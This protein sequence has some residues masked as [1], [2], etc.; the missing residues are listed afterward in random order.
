MVKDN[1][2]GIKVEDLQHIFAFGFT[3][4]ENGHGFG[5]HSS[6]LSAKE[7]AGKLIAESQGEGCG[8]QFI[9]TLP[10]T[11]SKQQGDIYG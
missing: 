10:I 11:D 8:A 3:T 1:G 6:A 5:L 4:K 7:M 2:V 9:L